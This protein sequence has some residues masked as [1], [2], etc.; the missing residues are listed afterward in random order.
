MQRKVLDMLEHPRAGVFSEACS[1]LRRQI[2][3]DYRAECAAAGHQQHIAADL[4]DVGA[5]AL[6]NPLI[7][8]VGH[9]GREIQIT[10]RLQKD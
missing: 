4:P 2:T 8:D 6:H 10:H 5:V 9:Q 7:D 1:D 3:G